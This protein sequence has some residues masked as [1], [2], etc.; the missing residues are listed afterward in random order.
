M[1]DYASDVRSLVDRLSRRPV[2]IGWSMG[3]LVALM[4]AA[5][6]DVLACVVLEPS[7]PALQTDPSVRVRTGEYDLKEYGIL[8]DDPTD[9]PTMPDLD[10]DERSLA[11]ASCGRESRRARDERKAGIVID[12]IACPLLVV[13]G[14]PDGAWPHEVNKPMEPGELPLDA[15][16]L[17]VEGSSHWGLV[18]NRRALSVAAPAVV[19]WLEAK[20]SAR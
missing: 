3:G 11:L 15:E 17:T 9:Q 14:G 20:L 12:S 10:L 7:P 18:L 16:F 5:K 8:S 19:G 1:S 6:A 4:V 2:V 13:N